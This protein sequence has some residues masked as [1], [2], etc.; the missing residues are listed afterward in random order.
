MRF[1]K[2]HR[3]KRTDLS[4]L[5]VIAIFL[6]SVPSFLAQD[7]GSD[8]TMLRT[9]RPSLSVTARDGG[10]A[11]ITDAGTVKLYRDAT[12]VDQAG[13]SHGRAFFSSLSF[14]DYTL[15]VEANGYKPAQK[16]VN[17]SVAMRYEI[18][19]NLQ[20]EG[21]T[22][23]VNLP[24]KPLLAPKAKEAL[25]KSVRALSK[26]KFSEAE[27]YLAEA[28]Q[29]AP[30]HPDVLFVQ[31]VLLL[32]EKHWADAQNVLEKASQMD[33][34][35]ALAFSRLG[36]ALVDEGKYEQAIA[37]AEKSLQIDAAA[38]EPQWVLG[39]SYY[40]LQQYDQALK[41]SQLAWTQSNGKEPRIELLLAKSLTAVGKYED[42][43]QRLRDFLKR[44]G[45]RP[46]APTARRWLDGLAKNG[47]IRAD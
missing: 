45:D 24:A 15:V 42:A 43:A 16:D 22:N 37:P 35:N 6:L 33:P 4:L 9:D 19:A 39:E 2:L 25:D 47:K 7:S 3:S 23:A 26:N 10:G 14:G 1:A 34:T 12:L 46:E 11:T 8:G 36:M 29:L 44:Y 5:L 31:G 21:T 13:L 32:D 18:D 30:G 27:K 40:H 41:A 17:V 28:R 20:R 38:W